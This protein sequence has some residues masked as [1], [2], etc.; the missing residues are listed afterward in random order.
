M[1]Y[2]TKFVI[3]YASLTLT[4]SVIL[5]FS[6]LRPKDSRNLLWSNRLM[7]MTS[8][9][10]GIQWKGPERPLCHGPA[11]IVINHQSSIDIL[12]LLCELLPLMEGQV[13]IVAK[14][15]LLYAGPFG[16]LAYM[17]GVTFIERSKS[18]EAK[19]VLNEAVEHCKR[20]NWKMVVFPEGTRHHHPDQLD[21][22]P[23]KLG[24]FNA[25]IQGEI[26][27]QPIVFSHY[28]F[29]DNTAKVLDPGVIRI[30]VLDTQDCSQTD[31]AKTLALLTRAKMLDVFKED[32]KR[33]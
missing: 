10:L 12:G 25:A 1:S 27:V 19:K 21:M 15:S 5:P 11:V 7:K 22:L 32:E 30:H 2:Y 29:Y 31:D 23:F 33:H 28:N 3:Y 16:L 6:L 4:S 8:A 9:L 26:P 18:E 17:S 20:N 14:K 13:T 24:A